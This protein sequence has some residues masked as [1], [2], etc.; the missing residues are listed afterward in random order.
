MRPCMPRP[1]QL[2]CRKGSAAGAASHLLEARAAVHRLVAAWL[3]GHARLAPAVAA[4]RGEH[5]A[6]SATT[7]RALARAPC[8][9]ARWA[10]AR[11]VLQATRRVELLFAGGPDELLAT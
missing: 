7:T 4:G 2:A 1:M 11:W 9:A 10:A 8:G 6:R 3:E 5:L